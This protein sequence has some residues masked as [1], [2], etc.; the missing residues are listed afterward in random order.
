M[1]LGKGEKKGPE[2]TECNVGGVALSAIRPLGF[3][4]ALP[5]S[6]F[7]LLNRLPEL[8]K[9]GGNSWPLVEKGATKAAAG[10]GLVAGTALVSH[11][12]RKDWWK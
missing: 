4:S 5:P 7:R 9:S 12:R 6:Y 8:M 2:K 11:S 1:Y 10:G 3:S